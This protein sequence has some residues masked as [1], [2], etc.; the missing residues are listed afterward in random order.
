MLR[1][2]PRTTELSKTVPLDSN[3]SALDSIIHNPF[4]MPWT[5]HLKVPKNGFH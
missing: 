1:E 3:P 5:E 4:T 2:M